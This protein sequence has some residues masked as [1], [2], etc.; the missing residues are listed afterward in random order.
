MKRRDAHI[1]EKAKDG[2]YVEPAW[3]SERLFEEE[4]FADTIYDPAC[5]WGTILRSAQAAGYHNVIGGDV[6][7]RRQFRFSFRQTDFLN[8]VD[9]SWRTGVSVV[10]N[11]P[12]D[13]VEEFCR[14]ACKIANKVA[15]IMLM[16]RLNAA[17]WLDDLPL[18][19]VYL[20]TPRPSMPPGAWIAAG[21]K[22]GGG[23]QD[24][25]WLVFSKRYRGEP[26]LQW[27]NRDEQQ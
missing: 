16:R 8:G 18:K 13:H 1:F 17:H 14:K 24:F 19:M 21:N 20:L 3:V 22:P 4:K 2:F 25:C 7:D 12:F 11:P 6:V 10:C 23:T 9:E 5:G 15:M 26:Q 27:L